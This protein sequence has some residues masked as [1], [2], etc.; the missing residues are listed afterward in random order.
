M[1]LQNVQVCY[2]II[3]TLRQRIKLNNRN[4]CVGL[5][6]Y[7]IFVFLTLTQLTLT[8]YSIRTKPACQTLCMRSTAF[9][10]YTM[11]QAIIFH[12]PKTILAKC[13]RSNLAT[14]YSYIS[15]IFWTRL[16]FSN[17]CN[18]HVLFFPIWCS[19]TVAIRQRMCLRSQGIR[20]ETEKKILSSCAPPHVHTCWLDNR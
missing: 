7:G 9:R 5:F 8:K 20:Y 3:L 6:F 2:K 10:T 16:G 18:K 14:H 13:R 11:P 1:V 19:S 12:C 17:P 4:F 15:L